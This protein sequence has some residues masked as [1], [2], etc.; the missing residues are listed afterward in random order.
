MMEILAS[1]P[2]M[3]YYDEPLNIRRK[4]VQYAGCF[5]EWRELMPD[6][7]RRDDI[8]AYLQ[9]LQKNR[10]GF[11]N[12]LPFRRYHRFVTT[13][14][15]FKMH[16]VEHLINDIK[17]EC[18]GTVV[19]LLRHPIPTTLSRHTFP[20]LDQFVVSCHYEREYLD[21]AQVREIRRIYCGGNKF[22]RGVL[23]WCF[24][25]LIPL[26]F[27]DVSDWFVLTYEELLLNSEMMCQALAHSLDLPSVPAMMGAVN[28]P[29]ANIAM[30]GKETHH[31]LGEA[32]EGR[33]RQAMVKKWKGRITEADEKLCF[34]VLDTFGIDAYR[35]GRFVA[36]E[37]YLHFR[38][39]EGLS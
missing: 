2:G 20:R 24:E 36:D 18:N 37:R 1:Q 3:K 13:R 10:Y 29:A 19:F 9:A 32:D 8:I 22:Q 38:D 33:R 14:N 15:V 34:E 6:G 35:F 23:S 26:R 11:M 16:G 27:S 21:A 12:P 5:Q 39:T 17:N 31:I 30:S 4:N 25:N 7:N 28:R